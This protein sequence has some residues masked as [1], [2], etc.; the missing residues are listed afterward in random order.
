MPLTKILAEIEVEVASLRWKREILKALLDEGKVSQKVF[1]ALN[2]M[3]SEIETAALN[4]KEK[5]DENKRFWENIVS[6]EN[7][8]LEGLLVDLKF[9]NLIGELD[10]PSWQSMSVAIELG[11]GSISAHTDR[12]SIRNDLSLKA[13]ASLKRRQNNIDS[14]P[15]RK[16]KVLNERERKFS[17]STLESK[18]SDGSHCM[19]PWKPDCRRTDIKLSIYYEGRFLP[20]CNECWR[21]IAEKNIEWTG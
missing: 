19:N 5:I 21:E 3:M 12:K 14:S 10:E 20:I 17:E 6:E 4:L 13:N 11:M 2:S 16:N 7:K 9:K 15:S 18:P 8:I 1:N